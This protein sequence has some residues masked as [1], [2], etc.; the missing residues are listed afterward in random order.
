MTQLKDA[1]ERLRYWTSCAIRDARDG[2]GA[3][4]A[5]TAAVEWATIVLALHTVE[6]Q[7]GTSA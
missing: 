7:Q 4:P 2:R 3:G 6:R 1:T 5:R